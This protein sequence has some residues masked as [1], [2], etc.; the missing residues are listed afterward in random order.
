MQDRV[1]V[2]LEKID[3]LSPSAAI[4]LEKKPPI[5]DPETEKVLSLRDPTNLRF[6]NASVAKQLLKMRILLGGSETKNDQGLAAWESAVN[7]KSKF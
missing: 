4:A 3:A 2:L 7:T 1:S 5:Q 6:S